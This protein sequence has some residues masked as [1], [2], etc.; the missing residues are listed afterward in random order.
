MR[1]KVWVLLNKKMES[2]LIDWR[3]SAGGLRHSVRSARTVIDQRHLAD[4]RAFL[5]VLDDIIAEPDVPFPLPVTRTFC[6]AYRLPGKGNR[7]A[8]AAPRRFVDGKVLQDS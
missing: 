2:P 4:E 7:R 6:H 5:C 1:R 3:Q 8:L